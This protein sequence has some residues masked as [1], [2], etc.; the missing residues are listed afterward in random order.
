MSKCLDNDDE[1]RNNLLEVKN[2]IRSK[3]K[4]KY[5]A[6]CQKLRKEIEENDA[7]N[8]TYSAIETFSR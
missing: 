7:N 4:S 8:A 6:F 3:A 1:L 5:D 2:T